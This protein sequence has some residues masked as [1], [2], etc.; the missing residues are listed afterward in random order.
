MKKNS[1]KNWITEFAIWLYN[2]EYPVLWKGTTL[3]FADIAT[4][5]RILVTQMKFIP[6]IRYMTIHTWLELQNCSSSMTKNFSMVWSLHALLP[7]PLSFVAWNQRGP[8]YVPGESPS[9]QF[10]CEFTKCQEWLLEDHDEVSNQPYP[11]HV[12]WATC[13]VRWM[14]R[15]GKQWYP[16]FFE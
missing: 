5:R 15:P 13:L 10:V 2:C 16:S 12:R 8:G 1:E 7:E 11:R 6:Q 9:T 3:V 4:A 14:C